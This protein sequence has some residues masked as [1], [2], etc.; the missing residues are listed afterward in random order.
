VYG[1]GEGP[2]RGRAPKLSLTEELVREW[3]RE[4]EEFRELR[5]RSADWEFIEGQPPHVRAAL[6]YFIERG[7]RYVAAKIA[8]LTVDEFDELRRRA[9]IPVVV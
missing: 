2:T 4:D 7:D 8:G 6:L 5:R 3:E 9:S 1:R